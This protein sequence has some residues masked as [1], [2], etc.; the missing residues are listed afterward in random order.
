MR[1]LD[2]LII[3]L[4]ENFVNNAKKLECSHIS[5]FLCFKMIRTSSF[6]KIIY[7]V[8][9][10]TEVLTLLKNGACILTRFQIKLKHK[11]FSP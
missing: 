2:F 10:C 4:K 9:F 3:D 1:S 11:I 6:G 5:K 8:K 7:G